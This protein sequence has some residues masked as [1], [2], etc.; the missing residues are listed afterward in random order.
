[1]RI[2]LIGPP[3]AGKGT[4][5]SLM[6]ARY[7]IIHLSTGEIL[8][9]EIQRRTTLGNQAKVYIDK[10]QLVPDKLLLELMEQR[11]QQ[12]DCDNGYLLDGFP[13]TIPQAVGL[14]T[15]LSHLN[16]TLDMVISLSANEDEL[17]NRLVLRGKNSGR[18]DDTPDVIRD[19]QKV[20]W[21]QT[22]PLLEFYREQGILR[23]VDGQGTID[24][25]FQRIVEIM[26]TLC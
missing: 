12:P 1:M 9:R 10:G 17:V 5:A 23:E 22:A 25:V 3:G 19:R 11:L 15:I 6:E 21:T 16:T 18:S 8:R 2:V 24:N 26:D 14:N 20:Y 13:R 4:Q 7:H